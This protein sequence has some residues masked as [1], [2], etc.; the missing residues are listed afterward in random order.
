[1]MD[2]HLAGILIVFVAV[3][4]AAVVVQM[5]VLIAMYGTMRKSSARVRAVADEVQSKA[6]PLMATAQG[7]LEDYR[8]KVDLILAN[9][10]DTSATVKRD[11]ALLDD[12]LEDV[13][14][15]ARLQVIRVDDLVSRT[16]DR[17]ESASELVHHSV[18]SPLRQASGLLQ[19]ITAAL[20]TLL[21]KG[22]YGR[23]RS[24]PGVPK[25]DLFI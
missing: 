24:G 4:A 17:V 21:N 8:P 20:A 11:V 23:A 18:I 9:L 10:E 25:D 15:R 12:S 7:M 6:L 19:G 14:G 5:V 16:L 13:V 2:Q 3:T 22:P 1:M